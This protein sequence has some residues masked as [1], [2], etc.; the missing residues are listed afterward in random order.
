[1]EFEAAVRGEDYRFSF[2]NNTSVLVSG[3]QGEYILYK[4][5]TWRCADDLPTEIVEEFGDIIDQRLPVNY[6]R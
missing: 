6:S 3:R 5:K 1:M 4:N 2:L